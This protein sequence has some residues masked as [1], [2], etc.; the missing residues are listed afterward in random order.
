MRDSEN[1]SWDD[2]LVPRVT[3][4]KGML[5]L[6]ERDPEEKLERIA[7]GDQ[8]SYFYADEIMCARDLPDKPH[9]VPYNGELCE[10][11]VLHRTGGLYYPEHGIAELFP[12]SNIDFPPGEDSWLRHG[13]YVT[14]VG[15]L[16]DETFLRLLAFVAYRIAQ[17]PEQKRGKWK[18]FPASQILERADSKEIEYTDMVIGNMSRDRML[19]AMKWPGTC[20][21]D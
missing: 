20:F 17:V 10:Y 8:V 19:Y 1:W 13:I 9:F 3:G 15:E 12:F 21:E 16:K 5:L 11:C 7:N 14:N 18:R 4:H 2:A 6:A